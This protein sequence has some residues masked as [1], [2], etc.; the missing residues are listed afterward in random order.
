[1]LA[2]T[3]ASTG[4]SRENSKPAWGLYDTV[5]R[6]MFEH[7]NFS[8]SNSPSRDSRTCI[9]FRQDRNK[10]ISEPVEAA[11][12]FAFAEHPLKGT[13]VL[14]F[15][16]CPKK[17]AIPQR[18]VHYPGDRPGRFVGR[19]CAYQKP[20]VPRCATTRS[21]C[22]RPARVTGS[23]TAGFIGLPA[24]AI[25]SIASSSGWINSTSAPDALNSAMP[26]STDTSRIA[27]DG[28]FRAKTSTRP[29][30]AARSAVSLE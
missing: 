8:H 17:L 22:A 25:T 5:K 4:G 21:P 11:Q 12:W 19:F 28:A 15:I 2:C 13:L 14:G 1:M 6:D 20:A 24:E 30:S 18:P 16:T 27:H 7:T 9:L 10:L 29:H 3:L 26:S 23:K